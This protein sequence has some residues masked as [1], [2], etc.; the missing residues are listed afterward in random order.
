M[1]RCTCSRDRGGAKPIVWQGEGPPSTTA[2]I[3]SSSASYSAASS[4]SPHSAPTPSSSP[5]SSSISSSSPQPTSSDTLSRF[6]IRAL[7]TAMQLIGVKIL[8]VRTDGDLEGRKAELKSR[9]DEELTSW[10]NAFLKSLFFTI[11][12]AV[13]CWVFPLIPGIESS[14]LHS[15]HR[16]LTVKALLLWL[17]VTPVQFGFGARFYRNAFKALK[18][19]AANMDVL[20][21][22]G[23]SA[24]YFYSL[25][26]CI[27]CLANDVSMHTCTCALLSLTAR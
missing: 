16:A 5:P 10:R 18:H 15:V 27:M 23:S 14:L 4:P 7:V 8:S 6:S 21:A 3:Q 13:V 2:S 11:P 1:L 9:R 17:L 24:A 22:L 20:I 12:I 25:I 19:K 26:V